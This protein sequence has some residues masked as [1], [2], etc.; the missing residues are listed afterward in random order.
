MK[1]LHVVNIPFVVPYFLGE[2]LP[3][4]GAKGYEEFVACSPSKELDDFAK[5]YE[6]NCLQVEI[7][8]KISILKDLKAVFAVA[9]YIR[10]NKIDIVT[11]HTPKGAMVAMLAAYISRVPKR[12]YLRHGLVYETAHGLKRKLLIAIDKL[13]ATLAT[14]VI[15][16]SPSV[17][18]RSLDDGLNKASKQTILANGT[19]NGIDVTR[20]DI[21]TVASDDIDQ[22]KSSL[23]ISKNDIVIGYVGRLV[24][25]KG[26]IEL[27]QAFERLRGEYQNLKLLLVGMLEERDALPR[28]IVNSIKA[29]PNIITTGYVLNSEIEKYYAMMDVFVLPSYREGFPT[30]VLEAS[31]MSIPVV[32][33]KVTGCID[34]I[35]DG[36]T[37]LFAEHTPESL[38]NQ[39]GY[40]CTD[41]NRRKEY[42]ANGRKFVVENF[43]QEIIWA[44]IEKLYKQ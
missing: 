2:Q 21:A 12:I 17:A 38:A 34:S 31:S 16:V 28:E 8:R 24:R 25:D 3:Y 14:D 4:F 37:G 13:A 18:R 19:C 43:R 20:F 29:N 42:G 22:L 7:L 27:V 1:V 30:S 11:G 35:L 41:E 40:F 33:T 36:K 39:I 9:K 26:I 15:C 32:T 44:E 6:F 23:G 10:K 5:R